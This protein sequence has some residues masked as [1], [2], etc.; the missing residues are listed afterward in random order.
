MLIAHLSDSHISL[1]GP[2]DQER[3]TV[4]DACVAAINDLESPPDLVVHTGDVVHNGTAAEYAAASGILGKLKAPLRVIPGNKDTRSGL[5][6]AFE[7]ASGP[8]EC[9]GF[10]QFAEDFERIRCIFLDTKSDTSNKGIMCADRIAHFEQSAAHSGLATL[11]FMHHPPFDVWTAPEPFQFEERCNAD[12]VFATLEKHSART[13]LV[14]GHIHRPW[15]ERRGEIELRSVT[16]LAR[17]LRKG[18]E[19]AEM[20]S[21]GFYVLYRIEA[22][23]DITSELRR[24]QVPG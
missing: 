11:V 6:Q 15:A 21:E 24:L 7:K 22:G 4:L 16:A 13:M 8:R 14:A 23:G 18:E 19:L 2:T 5:R 1:G 9:D 12:Q 10:V 3:L 17:D 20:A